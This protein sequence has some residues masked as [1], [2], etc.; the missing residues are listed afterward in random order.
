MTAKSECLQY[1]FINGFLR[2]MQVLCYGMACFQ[3]QMIPCINSFNLIYCMLDLVEY[4]RRLSFWILGLC[5]SVFCNRQ[6][7]HAE[8]FR[9]AVHALRFPLSQEIDIPTPF[10]Y[11]DGAFGCELRALVRSIN[12]FW[13]AKPRPRFDQPTPVRSAK[14]DHG[15]IHYVF[16]VSF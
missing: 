9:S 15:P 8:M 11:V 5:F 4:G 16:L 10:R 1:Y 14:L 2:N 3:C 12:P 7:R 13:C 6:E